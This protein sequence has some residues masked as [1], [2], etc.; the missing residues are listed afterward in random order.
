MIAPKRML[1]MKEVC[2]NTSEFVTGNIFKR[3]FG[4]TNPAIIPAKTRKVILCSG[5]IYYDLIQERERLNKTDIAILRIEQ[6]A[7]FPFFSM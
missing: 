5:Q 1:K 7:P 3:V 2:S 4:E 6:L